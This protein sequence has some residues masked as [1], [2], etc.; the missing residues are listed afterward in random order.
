MWLILGGLTVTRSLSPNAVLSAL[1]A[2]LSG[3][4][5]VAPRYSLIFWLIV[6]N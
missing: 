1:F 3:S 5:V 6:T 4:L 2:F